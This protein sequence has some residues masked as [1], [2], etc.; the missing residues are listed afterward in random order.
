MKTRTVQAAW[1]AAAIIVATSLITTP[2]I[3][4]QSTVPTPPAQPAFEVASVRMV[5]EGQLGPA[6]FS[7]AGA[8]RYSV[9]NVPLGFLIQVAFGIDDF[10][11][12]NRPGWMNS[13]F[14]EVSANPA[15]DAPLTTNN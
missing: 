1:I 8:L 4:G 3:S 12:D 5:P 7:P 14:Y 10:Q 6:T 15:G 11:I 2:G 9:T 13:T